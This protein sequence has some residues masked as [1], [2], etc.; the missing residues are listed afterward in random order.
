MTLRDLIVISTGNLWRMKLRA[1][2][3]IAGVLIAIGAFVS[4]VS[5]GAGNQR[6]IENQFNQ[7][8][9]FTTMTVL[10]KESD[11]SSVPLDAAALERLATVPGVNL[12][13]PYDAF[14]VTVR[15]GDSTVKSKAQALPTSAVKTKLFS[16]LAAGSGFASDTARQVIINTELME[17]LGI[18][19]PDSA[20]GKKIVVSVHVSTIDSGL[21]HILKDKGE[22]V[23]DRIKRIRPDSLRYAQY[24][25]RVLRTE[26]NEVVRRFVNGFMNAQ[27]EVGDTLTI[28]GVRDMMMATR[29][30]IEPM[31]IPIATAAKFSSAGP[32]NN[33]TELFRAMTSGTL[34]QESSTRKNF[35]QVT[36]DFD[37]KVLYSTIK[38]SVESMGY[39]TFSFA[40]QFEQIQRMFIYLN[41]ALGVIG[42]I[43]LFTASLG[44]MNTMV[45]SINERRKEIGVLKSLGAD[46]SDIRRLFLVESAVIGFLGT[47]GG[48]LL[49]WG[50][51]RIVAT[52]GK[53]FMRKEGIPE[54]DLFAL[55]LWLILVALA[56]GVGI[57]IIA[58]LYP[59]ARASR[60]D[61]V[62]ALRNE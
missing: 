36:I 27:R 61:P 49:G 19:V 26:A 51:S 35:S 17:E 8:G 45:M 20:I 60:V 43:A 58:G 50:I 40:E 57:S 39:R 31:F 4:M 2:L 12:V 52:V 46:D 21:I 3:T 44:I 6:N 25:N 24:R 41:L 11:S 42:L 34:F 9:L 55:P 38:D 28:A 37:P 15:L 30:R 18:T 22:T 13:Y 48:I 62:A 14:A 32:G 54:M 33:P 56:V 7:L 1:T 5:F 53:M 16:G 23:I 47:I 10:P 29:L 59:A